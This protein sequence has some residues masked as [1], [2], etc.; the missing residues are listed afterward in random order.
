MKRMTLTICLSSLGAATGCSGIF[1]DKEVARLAKENVL[2][3]TTVE[4]KEDLTIEELNQ[5]VADKYV[6]YRYSL[7]GDG[8][9]MLL[10][11]FLHELLAGDKISVKELDELGFGIREEDLIR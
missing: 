6:E 3:R 7:S 10:S 11:R 1:V 8:R 9:G 4:P 2:W 5:R